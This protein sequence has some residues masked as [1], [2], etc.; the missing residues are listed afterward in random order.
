MLII[1]ENQFKITDCGII[2]FFGEKLNIYLGNLFK[3]KFIKVDKFH[4]SPT[5]E[6]SHLFIHCLQNIFIN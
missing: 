6:K 3:H 1:S 2:Y 4:T 5:P